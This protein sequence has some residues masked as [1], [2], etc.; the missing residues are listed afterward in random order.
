[1]NNEDKENQKNRIE[2]PNGEK[3][4]EPIVKKNNEKSS[5]DET[6]REVTEILKSTFF[7]MGHISDPSLSPIISKMDGHHIDRMLDITEK[8]ENM[9]FKDVQHSR[10]YQLIYI[11]LAILVFVFLTIFLVG[12][13]TELFKEIIKLFIIFVGGVGAG[14]GLKTH[15]NKK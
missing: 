7:S 1:M 11:I 10:I 9:A 6:Q 3:K 14:F 4:E 15:I 12:K 8:S 5:G 2:P 13:D